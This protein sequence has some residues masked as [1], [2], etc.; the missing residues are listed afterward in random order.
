VRL[1]PISRRKA[2][3]IL[4][5][6]IAAAS[7]KRAPTQVYVAHL[8]QERY[9]PKSVDHI[10]DVLSAVLRAAVKW[11]HLQENPARGVDLPKLKTV[12]PKWALTPMQAVALLER[13]SALGRAMAGLALLSGLR[14]G[15]LF[16]LRWR[17]IDEEARVLTV[18]EAV[19][20]DAFD[21]P[22]TEAGLRQVPLSDAALRF[23]GEWKARSGEPVCPR[24]CCSRN[25]RAKPSRQTTS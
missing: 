3:D 8:T 7:G 9:A 25:G 10:H 11:G 17:D 24:S 22:K 20:D 14:R 12:R 21:T 15:E 13:L 4:G 16:A 6:K 2:S 19:Y 18:R 5:Q 23:I 1:G